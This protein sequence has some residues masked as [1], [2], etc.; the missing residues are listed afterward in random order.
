M[1]RFIYLLTTLLIFTYGAVKSETFETNYN[2]YTAFA[3]DND[4]FYIGL[5][6]G[7]V[8]QNIETGKSTY[9]NSINSKLGTNYIDDIAVHNGTVYITGPGGLFTYADGIIEE[10]VLGG[11]G[12]RKIH[13]SNDTLWVYDNKSIYSH[14]GKSTKKYELVSQ[15][16]A[17]YEIA[18]ISLHENNI[19]ISFYM[20][21]ATNEIYYYRFRNKAYSFAV[22][23]IKNNEIKVISE[24]ERGFDRYNGISFQVVSNNE[25][26]VATNEGNYYL[27]DLKN[28]KWRRN[29]YLD[30]IPSGFEFKHEDAVVDENGDVW[31][32]VNQLNEYRGQP[33]KYNYESN[34][35]KL[36]FEDRVSSG[37]FYP[38]DYRVIEDG[39]FMSDAYAF[40]IIKN[41]EIQVISSTQLVTEYILEGEVGYSK[42]V[43]YMIFT[44]AYNAY[45]YIKI[46]NFGA[47]TLIDYSIKNKTTLPA[48]LLNAYI[49]DD[50]TEIVEGGYDMHYNYYNFIKKEEEWIPQNQIGLEREFNKIKHG[51]FANGDLVINPVE[52]L[53]GYNNNSL[54]A[55]DNANKDKSDSNTIKDFVVRDNRIYA[56]GYY[57]ETAE[58]VNTFISVLDKKNN[59]EF[60]YNESN[61]CLTD[62]VQHKSNTP[63][64]S[65]SIPE[66]ME[67]DNDGNIWVL[68][69]MSLFMIDKQLKCRY[70]ENIPKF[71]SRYPELQRMAYSTNKSTVYGLG[72][73][74][75]YSLSDEKVEYNKISH[76]G[77]GTIKYFGACSD[78]NVYVTTE[79]GGLYRVKN[80]RE[81]IPIEVVPG[82]KELGVSINHVSY[83]KDTLYLST[84]VGLFKVDNRLTSVEDGG[85]E[86]SSNLFYP[87]P[88][89]DFINIE[90]ANQTVTII[91]L[92]GR[93]MKQV[94]GETRIDISDLYSGVYF[95][96]ICDRIEKLVKY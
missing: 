16:G 95:V 5:H 2:R 93:I 71:R 79:E 27:Y 78:G 76:L 83:F 14:V 60:I 6:N 18:E 86:L 40:Y 67:I 47:R 19:W 28:D 81:L 74:Y 89:S 96:R 10:I 29:V 23:N 92:T 30:L 33:A 72:Y 65:D 82:K 52:G 56:Y 63:T 84:D 26:W 73:E 3:A 91:S 46:I 25:V 34:T 62:F 8:V 69:N 50:N 90:E 24:Q 31:F 88:S 53:F 12:A 94:T 64:Y 80:I 85:N 77:I 4:N 11:G 59:E 35:V 45:N 87:N 22:L 15:L 55:Y 51:R 48:P 58:D 61:T 70:I 43:Y 41:N 57:N 7:F 66:A 42:G 75:I 37:K 49:K 17:N 13:F 1:K 9:H 68:T 36:M 39:I 54:F 32:S 20:E 44:N 38:T 21:S